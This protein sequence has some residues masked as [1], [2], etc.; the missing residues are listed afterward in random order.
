MLKD[1]RP[2]MRYGQ[3]RSGVGG[4]VEPRVHK[5]SEFG[6]T[7]RRGHHPKPLCTERS[8]LWILCSS[9]VLVPKFT[10][11]AQN[12]RKTVRKYPNPPETCKPTDIAK[13]PIYNMYQWNLARE[14]CP[15]PKCPYR[16]ENDKKRNGLLKVWDIILTFT[17]SS[18]EEFLYLLSNFPREPEQHCTM[19]LPIREQ[20]RWMLYSKTVFSRLG[21]LA[22]VFFLCLDIR[23]FEK[24]Y[25][26]DF[27]PRVLSQ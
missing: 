5:F 9:L 13:I 19:H 1:G 3:N 10:R 17:T 24:S 20:F 25:V 4:P 15:D 18:D 22:P 2:D 11:T 26:G 7:T 21:C 14:L 16:H 12:S 23:F 8:R 6:V 27:G